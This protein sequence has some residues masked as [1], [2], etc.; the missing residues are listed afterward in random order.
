MRSGLVKAEPGPVLISATPRPGLVVQ[1][2]AS[3]YWPRPGPSID[4]ASSRPSGLD[5][6]GLVNVGYLGGRRQCFILKL[7]NWSETRPLGRDEDQCTDWPEDASP[8]A[9]RVP[10][11]TLPG[12]PP[13]VH[14]VLS[15]GDRSVRR[16][17][18]CSGVK[19]PSRHGRAPRCTGT[20]L[21][22]TYGSVSVCT[23]SG[24]VYRLVLLQVQNIN[25]G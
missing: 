15:C 13:R 20:Y 6:A 25:Q 10:P 9:R 24:L 17:V 4:L 16:A 18:R 7:L 21:D 3:A 23:S 19:E 5:S 2:L 11:G 14:P 1:D 12:Y 8:R 22:L